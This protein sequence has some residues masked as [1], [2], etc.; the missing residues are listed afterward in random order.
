[1]KR[2]LQYDEPWGHAQSISDL[3]FSADGSQLASGSKD[4][5]INI[6]D[7]ASRQLLRKLRG[8]TQ[9]VWDIAYAHRGQDL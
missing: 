6:W 2:V 5:T 7:P 3:E 8:H 1:M 9:I 4:W